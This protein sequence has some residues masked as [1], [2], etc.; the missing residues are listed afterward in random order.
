VTIRLR[1]GTSYLPASPANLSATVDSPTQ[2]TLKWD[3]NSSNE[4]GFKIERSP[5]GAN[6]WSQVGTVGPDVKTYPNAGLTCSTGYDYQMRTYN[7]LG[8]SEYSNLITVTTG[9]C[10]PSAPTTLKA[11]AATQSQIDLTWVDTS[12]TETGFKIERS[13][14][15]TSNWQQIGVTAVNAQSYPDTTVFCD[16]PY[17]YQVR[18]T[19]ETGDSGYAGPVNV[20]TPACTIPADAPASLTAVPGPLNSIFLRW[21]DT[22][23][24]TQYKIERSADGSK[25]WT[26]VGTTNGNVTAWM[27]KGPL[28]VGA[29]YYYRVRASNKA[30]VSP[31]SI[32]ANASPNAVT[33]CLPFLRR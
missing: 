9:V 27:D 25:G 32:T 21:S 17:Y 22:F 7:D 28:T 8:N 2:V 15:G 18:A 6:T 31:Y 4:T 29:T 24:E 23:N 20:H 14:D 11:T 12:S 10:G 33:I 5:V 3:D 26:Q 16:T 30:G 13:P 19:S 1:T